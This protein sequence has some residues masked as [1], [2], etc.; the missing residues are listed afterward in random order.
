MKRLIVGFDFSKGALHAF[1]YALKMAA[2]S[3]ADIRLV[4]VDNRSSGDAVFNSPANE[5]R[6]EAKQ[7]IEELIDQHK[8]EPG[9]GKLDYRLMK[10]KVGQELARHARDHQADYVI[11]GT[12]GITGFEEYWI[13]SNANRVVIYAHCPVITVRYDYEITGCLNRIVLPVDS[14]RETIQKLPPVA[15]LA[16]LCNAEVA[17]L[18]LYTTTLQTM[19]R[20]VDGR[21]NQTK[22]YL[23][24]KKIDYTLNTIKTDNI[25]RDVIAFSKE[26]EADLI[27]IISERESASSNMLLGTYAHKIVNHSIVP[28]LNVRAK[29]EFKLM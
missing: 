11:V 14:T 9:I 7:N 24:G 22:N 18:G 4:W 8:E 5:V 20:K 21:I 13:G 29:D 26:A 1:R 3:N 6:S 17:I 28:V 23:D 25:A 2:H 12:H 16:S 27:G 10:G 15:S 19:N